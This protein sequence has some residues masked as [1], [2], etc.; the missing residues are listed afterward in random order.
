MTQNKHSELPWSDRLAAKIKGECFA[1]IETHDGKQLAD[2]CG[3]F[4]EEDAA[5]ILKAC[6]MHYEL[7]EFIEWLS[8]DHDVDISTKQ[9]SDYWA[10]QF[11]IASDKAKQ[12]LNK[13]REE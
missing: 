6:N 5:F 13:A 7:V 8:L 12:L 3:C 4:S 11:R 10:S 2:D 1:W 9:R